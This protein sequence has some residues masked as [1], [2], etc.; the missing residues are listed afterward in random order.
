MSGKDGA[1]GERRKAA[2]RVL[3][4]QCCLFRMDGALSLLWRMGI[5]RKKGRVSLPGAR[6]TFGRDRHG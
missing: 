2:V 1:Y 5:S 4:V 3:G 6:D